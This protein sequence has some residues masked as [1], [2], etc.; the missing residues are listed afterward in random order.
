MAY[1]SSAIDYETVPLSRVC[2]TLKQL[3][4]DRENSTFADVDSFAA[5]GIKCAV[6][7]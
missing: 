5:H 4:L 1:E 7:D 6:A 2:F 3:I